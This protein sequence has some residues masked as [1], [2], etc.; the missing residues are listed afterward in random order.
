MP[1]A[2]KD[3]TTT[4][5]QNPRCAAARQPDTR[6]GLSAQDWRVLASAPTVVYFLLA[7]CDGRSV[8]REAAALRWLTH[9]RRSSKHP[10]MQRMLDEAPAALDV[11]CEQVEEGQLSVEVELLKIAEIINA[12]LFSTTADCVRRELYALA[13]SAADTVSGLFGPLSPVPGRKTARLEMIALA[14]CL[15]EHTSLQR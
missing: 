11:F 12:E 1:T 8:S 6:Y 4:R 3:N 5:K 10:L 14:L 2:R 13:E 7:S 9:S 15:F